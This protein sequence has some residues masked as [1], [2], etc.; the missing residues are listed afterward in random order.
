MHS[1]LLI[2][3][4][5]YMWNVLWK[6]EKG[7]LRFVQIETQLSIVRLQQHTTTHH[8]IFSLPLRHFYSFHFHSLFTPFLE[9]QGIDPGAV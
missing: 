2:Y 3:I 1:F 9:T 8:R 4:A 7:F 5:V 6:E